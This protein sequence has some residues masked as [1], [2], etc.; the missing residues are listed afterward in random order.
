MTGPTFPQLV[1]EIRRRRSAVAL[2]LL[3]VRSVDSTNEL[4]RRVRAELGEDELPLP[5]SALIAWEQTAGHGRRGRG[6]S[7]PAGQ[8][9]YA[10]V[11]GRL[12]EA[13]RLS[14]LPL[15]VAARLA[16][17]LSPLVAGGCRLK[18]PNDLMAGGRKLGGV[19]VEAIG[20]FGDGVE[21]IVGFG[22]NHGQQGDE[23]PT[24]TA[25]SL[26]ALGAAPALA[27]LALR[28]AAEVAEELQHREPRARTVERWLAHSQH[29]AGDPLRCQLPD[30]VVE[31]RFL[32]LAA[33][34][35][36]RLEVEGREEVMVD[37]ELV[38]P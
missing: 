1:E 19:L 14:V 26:A 8:G 6:W 9:I 30:R 17:A 12:H 34:G 11:F 27:P 24:P 23:L 29:T 31:G 28:L 25:T 36:L 21:L 4:A 5:W 2:N 35:R 7:S 32:G 15:A 10:T 33:D 38:T 13:E 20:G 22:V 3:V 16:E 18:W 37:A